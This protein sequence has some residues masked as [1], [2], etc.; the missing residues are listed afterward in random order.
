MSAFLLSEIEILTC[1][2]RFCAFFGSF[3]CFH[4]VLTYCYCSFFRQGMVPLIN[5]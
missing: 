2:I 5:V 1:F 3:Y 4:S